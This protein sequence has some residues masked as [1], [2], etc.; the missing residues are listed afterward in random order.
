MQPSQVLPVDQI[1]AAAA[2]ASSSTGPGAPTSL[3]AFNCRLEELNIIDVA[4]LTGALV[5]CG[6][7]IFL[8]VGVRVWGG[9]QLACTCCQGSVVDGNCLNGAGKQAGCVEPP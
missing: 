8:C 1:T 3:R 6:E 9:G 7:S 5:W 2:G 4:M